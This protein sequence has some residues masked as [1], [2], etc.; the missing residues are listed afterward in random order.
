M[1]GYLVEKVTTHQ[2]QIRITYKG[3]A[4]MARQMKIELNAE[5]FNYRHKK[6]KG[7]DVHSIP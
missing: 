3:L 4:A 6:K 2:P 7:R 5:D 1:N